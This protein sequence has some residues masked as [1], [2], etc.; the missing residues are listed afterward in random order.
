MKIGLIGQGRIAESVKEVG[1]I[2]VTPSSARWGKLLSCSM[3]EVECFIDFSHGSAVLA[4]LKVLTPYRCPF[5]LARRDGRKIGT[6]SRL[7]STNILLLLA[8]QTV[9]SEPILKKAIQ[10]VDHVQIQ[11]VCSSIEM[12][13]EKKQDAP[14]GTA[15]QLDIPFLFESW[16]IEG[17]AS[18]V[19]SQ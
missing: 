7:G 8:L 13:H 11:F 2:A 10:A 16:S 6:R 17:G 15:Q 4:H 3:D 14:S 12:H 9:R 1:L 19:D 18:G 5:L